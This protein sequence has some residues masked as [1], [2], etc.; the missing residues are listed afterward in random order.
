MCPSSQLTA[1]RNLRPLRWWSTSAAP[2]TTWSPVVRWLLVTL[3]TSTGCPNCWA[4]K[5]PMT[6]G[7][8]PREVQTSVPPHENH[9]ITASSVGWER[10]SF[11]ISVYIRAFPWDCDVLFPAR[12]SLFPVSHRLFLSRRSSG[13]LKAARAASTVLCNMFQYNKLHKDYKLVRHTH[14]DS[15]DQSH[16]KEPCQRA[17]TS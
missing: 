7:R 6:T 15:E 1:S 2:S 14:V 11:L 16:P 8:R 4:S 5:R 9:L 10:V 12:S 3:R 17:V 13:G